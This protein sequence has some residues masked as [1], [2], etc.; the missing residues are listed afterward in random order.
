VA[1]GMDHGSSRGGQGARLP[2]TGPVRFRPLLASFAVFTLT[3]LALTAFTDKAAPSQS[4]TSFSTGV[5][6]GK[7][8][9]RS[10]RLDRDITGC[11]VNGLIAGRSGITINLNGHTLGGLGEGVGLKLADVRGVKV[12]GGEVRGFELGMLMHRARRSRIVGTRIAMSA[13]LGLRVVKSH[14]SLFRRVELSGNSDAAIRVHSSNGNRFRRLDLSG[15]GDAAIWLSKSHGTRLIRNDL[16]GNGDVGILLFYSD[17]ARV[18]R[19]KLGGNGDAG[20]LLNHADGAVIRRN[21]MVGNGDAGILLESS[22]RNRIRR[23]T[24]VFSSDSGIGLEKSSFNVVAGN[25]VI[26]NGE[27]ITSDGG[28]RNR[29]VHNRVSNNGGAGIEV[30]AESFKTLIKRNVADWN[31]GDGIYIEG[32]RTRLTRNSVTCN[33][34]MGIKAVVPLLFARLN[35][36]AGNNDALGCEGVR[37]VLM[38]NWR[39]CDVGE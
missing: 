15:N 35:W 22:H 11:K 38:P 17:R 28:L 10:V 24:A 2:T 13:D 32:A 36:A 6:C 3:A 21:S 5:H 33:G 31:G 27:G 23:N 12:R 16:G 20:I 25:R 29:I 30:A 39:G 18:R 34:G 14:R 26:G 19:N 4:V 8:L 7:V 37:C 9:Y 1:D